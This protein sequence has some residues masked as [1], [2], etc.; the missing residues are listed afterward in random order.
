MSLFSKKRKPSLL[1]R[2]LDQPLR[3][4][5]LH[6]VPQE[7]PTGFDDFYNEPKPQQR[8]A[9][10]RQPVFLPQAEPALMQPSLAPRG[11]SENNYEIIA[12]K[13]DVIDA[14]LDG[15]LRRLDMLERL[16]QSFQQPPPSSENTR[17][18]RRL[19]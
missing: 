5:D 15:L 8:T 18:P 12:S 9:P 6:D 10:P 2:E 1:E 14:K 11:F 16:M 19:W 3:R 7:E 17:Y 4:S 13:I